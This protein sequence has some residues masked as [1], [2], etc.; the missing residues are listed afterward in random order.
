MH[1]AMVG[2]IR[3][4]VIESEQLA[5]ELLTV[6]DRLYPGCV[7]ARYGTGGTSLE[8]IAAA[9]GC[10]M[11]GN[12]PDT[13]RCALRITDDFRKGKFGKISLEIPPITQ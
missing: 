12:E 1:L 10:L 8:E 7:E 11:K 5:Y 4:E 2:S 9:T 3:D 6:L 13:R